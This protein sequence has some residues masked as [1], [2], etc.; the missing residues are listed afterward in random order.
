MID[1]NYKVR[2]YITEFDDQADEFCG[3]HELK[4]FDLALFQRVVG[5]ESA[6]PMFDCYPI[7]QDNCAFLLEYLAQPVVWDF[8]EKSYFVEA[9]AH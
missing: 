4:S 7:N 1:E 8:K 9:E 3:E 5:V 6:N 2:R